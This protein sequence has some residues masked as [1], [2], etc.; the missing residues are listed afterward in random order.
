MRRRSIHEHLRVDLRVVWE[1]VQRDL[2]QLVALAEPL[3]PP[4]RNVQ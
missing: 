2:P 1:A 4:E 3:V